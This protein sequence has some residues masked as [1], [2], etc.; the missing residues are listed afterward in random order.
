MQCM[1]AIGPIFR[2]RRRRRRWAADD[3]GGGGETM[4]SCQSGL[5]GWRDSRTRTGE[6]SGPAGGGEMPFPEE[7]KK[8]KKKKM[9]RRAGWNHDII[10]LVSSRSSLCGTR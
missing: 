1:L 6:R 7:K 2:R 4:V 5:A 8:K 9:R 3:E 10:R